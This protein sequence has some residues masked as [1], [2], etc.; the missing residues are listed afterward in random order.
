MKLKARHAGS[1][2][3]FVT[4]AAGDGGR[5]GREEFRPGAGYERR[6]GAGDTAGNTLFRDLVSERDFGT[7]LVGVLARARACVCVCVCAYA[8]EWVVIGSMFG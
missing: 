1:A 8:G 5:Q 7:H 2:K 4:S 6:Y 3:V